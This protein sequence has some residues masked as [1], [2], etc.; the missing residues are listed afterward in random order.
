MGLWHVN[1]P[2]SPATDWM[3]PTATRTCLV[4][5]SCAIVAASLALDGQTSRP[6]TLQQPV[7]PPAIDL[8][9]RRQAPEPRQVADQ[10]QGATDRVS[11]KLIARFDPGLGARGRQQMAAAVGATRMTRPPHADFHILTVDPDADVE[12]LAASLAVRPGVAYAQA[13]YV[14]HPYFRPN[15]PLFDRQWNLHVLDMERAWDVNRGA[16]SEIIAAVLDSGVAFRTAIFRFTAGPFTDEGQRYPALGTIDVPFAAAPDLDSPDRFVSPRDLI[17]DDDTPIDMD[18]HGTHVTGTLG[19]VTDNGVGVA[20]MAFNVRIM[21][22]KVVSGMWDEIFG[23]PN[24]GTDDV[25]ARGIRYAVDNG[26]RILTMSLGRTGPPAP[27]VDA[28]LRYA[29]AQGAFVA[30]AAG[31][32]FALDNPVEV[33]AALAEDIEGVMAVGAVGR[34]LER[35]SY[36]G[37][38]SYVEIVAPG[39]DLGQGGF[40][41]LILQQTYDER[42]ALTYLDPP[43]RFGPPRFDVFVFAGQQGTSMATPHVAGLAALLMQQ[44]ITSPA[45]IEAAIS[46]FARD[47]GDPGRDNETGHGLIDP[48]ATLRGL[49]LAR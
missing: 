19:Q 46:R 24:V 31:N 10:R 44:G 34:D 40:D 22:V 27:V 28:A 26:A 5:A 7:A 6:R 49:G 20:G 41:G 42:F 35:A 25:V 14:V 47:L 12:T 37:V 3:R 8:G 4:L 17:W 11:G 45:A 33:I 43:T 38:H 16:T 9:L 30:I 29:V 13:A 39:G 2:R 48:L 1:A 23:A 21:P 32:A 18:G 36:S 15:D